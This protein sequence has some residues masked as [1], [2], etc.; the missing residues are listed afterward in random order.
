MKKY[1]VRA[2]ETIYAIYEIEVDEPSIIEELHV[3]ENNFIELDYSYLDEEIE[4]EVQM[5][6]DV[7]DSLYDDEIND[8]NVAGMD[9]NDDDTYDDDNEDLEF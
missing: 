3:S 5:D 8:D 2:E 7:E 1:K 4:G 9:D 6:A